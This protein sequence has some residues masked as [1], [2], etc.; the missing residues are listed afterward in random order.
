MIERIK[1]FFRRHIDY[2]IT[3]EYLDYDGHG[4]YKKRYKHKYYWRW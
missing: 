4:H 2:R 3:G 1:R